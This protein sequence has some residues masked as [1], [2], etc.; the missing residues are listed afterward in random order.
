MTAMVGGVGRDSAVPIRHPSVDDIAAVVREGV[1][2]GA[3][4]L[5]A[6]LVDAVVVEVE[7]VARRVVCARRVGRGDRDRS[8]KLASS[9]GPPLTTSVIVGSTLLT[10]MV[11]EAGRDTTVPIRHSDVDDIAAIVREG[12]RGGVPGLRADLVD[13]VVVEVELVTQR[14]VSAPPGRSRRP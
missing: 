1:R 3:L 14:V 6:D 10:A 13:A 4:G 7:L 11:V 2:G 12:V 9:T 8:T 5:R